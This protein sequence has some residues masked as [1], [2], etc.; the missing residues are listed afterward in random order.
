LKCDK[1]KSSIKEGEEF[2][3]HGQFLC[4]DC[5]LDALSP[6]RTC[7]P[8]AVHSAKSFVKSQAGNLELNRTQQEILDILK[9]TDGVSLDTLVR[10]L[11]IK[12]A[13][14]ERELAALRHMEMVRG[15]LRNGVNII[16]L[17]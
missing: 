5:Y 9:G 10:R 2:K 11:K 1:C 13:D 6:L 8:W 16:R 7:D 4:E 17:W 14:I 12:R 15:G 3:L